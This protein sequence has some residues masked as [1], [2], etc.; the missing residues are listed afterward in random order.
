MAV[1]RQIDVRY[2]TQ[3]VMDTN[4]TGRVQGQ[5]RPLG[6]LFRD[7]AA[8]GAALMRQ[9]VALAK[10]ELRETTSALTR[11]LVRIMIAAGVALVGVLALVAFIIVALGDALDN[12]WLSSLIVAVVFLVAGGLL[13]RGAMK[14]M[15]QQDLK[16][17]A[18]VETLQADKAWAQREMQDLKQRVRA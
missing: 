13:A 9:E 14:D 4:G 15:K 5:E 6:E 3:P 1:E 12:Y 10:A 18:T 16:P 17:Q 7:L 8:D 2:G 11:D